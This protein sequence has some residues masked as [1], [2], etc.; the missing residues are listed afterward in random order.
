M[1]GFELWTSGIGSNRSTNWATTTAQKNLFSYFKL[2]ETIFHKTGFCSVAL[3]T[4]ANNN[5]NDL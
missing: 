4:Q 3:K 1:T 5:L 2:E